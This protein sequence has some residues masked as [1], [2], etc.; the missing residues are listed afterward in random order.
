MGNQTP[1]SK[2]PMT[3]EHGEAQIS[4]L[5]ASLPRVDAPGDFNF[6]VKARIA[7]GR[8]S[9]APSRWFPLAA[10]A[11]LPVAAIALIGGYF[12][13]TAIYSP[14]EGPAQAVVVDSAPAQPEI[15]QPVQSLPP[16]GP[17]QDEVAAVVSE[18]ETPVRPVQE[19]QTV[20]SVAVR[21]TVPKA[22]VSTPA[23]DEASFDVSAPIPKTL[24]P[25]EATPKPSAT[26]RQGDPAGEVLKRIGINALFGESGWKAESVSPDTAAAKAGVRAGDVI[27][28]VDEQPLSDLGSVAKPAKG[29]KVTVLRDGRS[30]EIVIEP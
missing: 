11:A 16:V 13:I 9:E 18:A 24:S 6:R 19:P 14:D 4:R 23:A 22:P 7:E 17:Q 10:R 20:R 21:N 1:Q 25:D 12:G 29:K 8:P 15:R 2:D 26:V 30:V 3:V 28:S 27:Q 5:L